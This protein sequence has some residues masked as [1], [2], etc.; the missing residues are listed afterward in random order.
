MGP[1]QLTGIVA[2]LRAGRSRTSRSTPAR[3][4]YFSHLRNAHTDFAAHS[5]NNPVN[6]GSS[7]PGSKS[8]EHEAHHSPPSSAEVKMRGVVPPLIHITLR[9]GG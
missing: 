3:T 7:A 5:A 9:A 1:R 6:T 2:N 8:A 4:T